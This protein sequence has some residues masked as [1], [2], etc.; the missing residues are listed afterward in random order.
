MPP[1]SKRLQEANELLT[2]QSQ[3]FHK[4]P[5]PTV[6]SCY[7]SSGWWGFKPLPI[8]LLAPELRQQLLAVD[9]EPK[10]LRTLHRYKSC[11]KC[12]THHGWRDFWHCFHCPLWASPT[13]G[14]GAR[15]QE[16]VNSRLSL[17]GDPSGGQ[18]YNIFA[19]IPVNI[20]NLFLTL[21]GTGNNASYSNRATAPFSS[22][23]WS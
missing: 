3:Q 6:P 11:K 15:V 16:A 7:F 4:A 22:I 14:L 20:K 9:G 17:A 1:K 8:H 18:H 19:I 12:T 2:E 13:R 21:I 5:F 10:A 23:S